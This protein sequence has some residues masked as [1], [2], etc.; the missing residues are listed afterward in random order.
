MLLLWP[1]KLWSYAN[2][3]IHLL[4]ALS[5]LLLLLQLSLITVII[6]NSVLIYL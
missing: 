1:L 3:E 4:L 6:I 2:V 5:S